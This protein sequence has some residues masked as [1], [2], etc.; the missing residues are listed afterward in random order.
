MI[1]IC[2][3]NEPHVVLST[4]RK[5]YHFINI[6][7]VAYVLLQYDIHIH[8][9]EN[10]TKTIKGNATVLDK[11]SKAFTFTYEFMGMT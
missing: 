2:S 4:T 7:R 9:Q 3:N 1:I 10:R 8:I 11:E 5:K 6:Y